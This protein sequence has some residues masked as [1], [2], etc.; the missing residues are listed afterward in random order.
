ME[1]EKKIQIIGQG[2]ELVKNEL[3]MQ[4]GVALKVRNNFDLKNSELLSD[5]LII[6][7]NIHSKVK[8]EI[9]EY[10]NNIRKI[11]A[12]T[13][14]FIEEESFQT[15]DEA[16][17]SL[18]IESKR[19]NNRLNAL[20]NA[21]KEIK[22]S[23]GTL[24]AVTEIFKTV[25]KSILE[26]FELSENES[27]SEKTKMLLKNSILV[28][29]FTNFMISFLKNF[30]LTG[31]NDLSLIRDDVFKDISDN[32]KND[33]DLRNKILSRSDESKNSQRYLDQINSRDE[34]RSIVRS[35]WD[36]IFEKLS[37]QEKAFQKSLSIIQDLEINR[38]NARNTM[39]MLNIAATTI[40]VSDSVD[41][42]ESLSSGMDG[43]ELPELDGQ[44]AKELLNIEF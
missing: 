31:V 3:D 14:Y 5:T 1:E 10:S 29:E 18:Q 38:D 6:N 41:M 44:L 11:I 37:G 16:V 19:D 25:N 39:E 13:A 36:Q 42:I 8:E 33:I 35:K 9:Q 24:I 15:I 4:V 2:S 28:Y 20:V 17:N 27:A 22:L 26:E 43:W 23:Y 21:Q 30:Q 7:R 40:I 32:E 12:A 34:F